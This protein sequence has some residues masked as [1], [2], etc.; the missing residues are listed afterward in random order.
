MEAST[1]LPTWAKFPVILGFTW[2]LVQLLC[3]RLGWL[4]TPSIDL[5]LFPCEFVFIIY[6][7][8]LILEAYY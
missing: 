6:I 4:K 2:I 8:H 5:I 7:F 1:L 3:T